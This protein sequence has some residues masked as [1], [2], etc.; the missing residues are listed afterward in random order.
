MS[1]TI[2]DLKYHFA[3]LGNKVRDGIITRNVEVEQKQ[4]R[5]WAASCSKIFQVS[6]LKFIDRLVLLG[7]RCIFG[8]TMRLSSSHLIFIP[9]WCWYK[10]PVI[11]SMNVR[12]HLRMLAIMISTIKRW[13]IESTMDSFVMQLW[14]LLGRTR[15]RPCISINSVCRIDI[16]KGNG[17][18]VTKVR[19]G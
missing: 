5:K 14:I 10:E 3:K 7:G 16:G 2:Y 6:R 19:W 11:L 15:D 18:N 13:I 8:K 4:V 9:M 12:S 1:H 17:R